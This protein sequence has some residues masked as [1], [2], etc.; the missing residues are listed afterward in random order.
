MGY[1]LREQASPGQHELTGLK[2]STDWPEQ[3]RPGQRTTDCIGEAVDGALDIAPDLLRTCCAH[4]SDDPKLFPI[5][6]AVPCTL[7]PPTQQPGAQ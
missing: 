5:T 4:Q 1:I 7:P 3:C 2:A 6:L